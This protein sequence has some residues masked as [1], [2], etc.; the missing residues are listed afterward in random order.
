MT[1]AVFS[2]APLLSAALTYTDYNHLSP[3][4]L[5]TGDGTTVSFSFPTVPTFAPV[6]Y[7]SDWQGNQLQYSTPRTNYASNS[8]TSTFS[9]YNGAETITTGIL[10]PDGST[11]AIT[12]SG[13]VANYYGGSASS[14]QPSPFTGT[15]NYG[16]WLKG[17]GTIHIDVSS[18]GGSGATGTQITLS[19]TWT[20]YANSTRAVSSSTYSHYRVLAY[21]GNTATSV[22]IAFPMLTLNQANF[23]D[24]IPTTSSAV[25]VT[26][27]SINGPING[28][29]TILLLS[30]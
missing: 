11:N 22:S 13:L 20:F 25:T 17:S 28:V 10:A 9:K 19:S 12:I 7:K 14:Y 3:V 27:Y 6:V 26:D 24:F 8:A 30:R 16:V 2:T 29:A 4:S 5:G 1:S 18:D 15:I 21:P 23:G